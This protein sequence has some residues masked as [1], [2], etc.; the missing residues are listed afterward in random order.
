M[1]C[2]HDEP[3]VQVSEETK[4]RWNEEIAL[5]VSFQ[6]CAA[7][8]PPAWWTSCSSAAQVLH[9]LQVQKKLERSS[10]QDDWAERLEA[11]ARDGVCHRAECLAR[12]LPLAMLQLVYVSSVL[13]SRKPV[14]LTWVPVLLAFLRAA[15]HQI[16]SRGGRAVAW[17]WRACT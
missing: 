8:L 11:A 1:L 16:G 13:A 6:H 14:E 2:F 7:R 10:K 9:L 12:G 5:K 15:F 3:P 17:R 4:R